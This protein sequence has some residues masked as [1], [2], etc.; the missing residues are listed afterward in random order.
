LDLPV[1]SGDAV[2]ALPT[3]KCDCERQ[4][5]EAADNGQSTAGHVVSKQKLE[6]VFARVFFLPFLIISPILRPSEASFLSAG[7]F[8]VSLSPSFNLP[9]VETH[10]AY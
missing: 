5:P 4:S 9:V 6:E 2:I 8:R 7:S 3:V 1:L 10:I